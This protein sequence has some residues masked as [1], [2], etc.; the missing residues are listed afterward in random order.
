LADFEKEPIVAFKG[1]PKVCVEKVYI[2]IVNYNSWCDTIECLE[3]VFRNNYSNYQ[4]V[5]VDNASSDKSLDFIQSW[6]NGQLDVWLPSSNTLRNLSSP[7]VKK[8][9]EYILY[10]SENF[11]LPK[12]VVFN[13]PSPLVLIESKDNGGFAAG[14]NIAIKY[15]MEKKDAA[16]FWLLN[17]DTV[18]NR[19]S[20]SLLVNYAKDNS[21]GIAGSSLMYYSEPQKIQALGGCVDKLFGNAKHILDASQIEKRLDYVVGASLCISAEVINSLGL[22]PEEYFMYYEETDYCFAAKKQ[23]FRLGICLDSLVFHKVYGSQKG[24]AKREKTFDMLIRSRIKFHRKHLG[25]GLF[26]WI[27][28]LKQFFGKILRGDVFGVFRII[29]ESL[30]ENRC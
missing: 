20:L 6:A 22:L 14:N 19:D 1:V 8:P 16:F 11:T 9:L 27:G 5:V 29:K 26:L 24:L 12:K 25:G 10:S 28:L 2:I 3:S 7:P 15:A 13:E 21:L 18:I 30:I 4:V 17:N 23:G